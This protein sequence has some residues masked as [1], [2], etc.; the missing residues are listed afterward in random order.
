MKVRQPRQKFQLIILLLVIGFLALVIQACST[1]NPPLLSFVPTQPPPTSEP[2]QIDPLA[3]VTFQ[4]EVPVDSPPGQPILLSILDEVTGL[5]LNIS[6]QEMQKIAESTYSITLPIPVGANIKYRYARQDSFIAEEHTTGQLPVRYRIYRVDGPGVVQDIVAAW[7]DSTYTGSTGRIMGRVR[8]EEDGMPIPNLMVTA[9]GAQSVTSSTGEYLIEGLPPGLHNL[10]LYALDGGFRTYQQGALIAENSTTP[11][12][13]QLARAPLVKLIF[14][15]STPESTLP[16]VPIR[17]AGNL[18]QLGNTFADLSGGMNSIASR[19]PTL[20]SLPDGRYALEIDLPAGAFLEYKYTL[21]DGFWNSEYTPQGNFRLRKMTV[22]EHD[23][24][25]EDSIDNWGEAFNPGPLLFDLTVPASTPDFDFVSI[26]FS[27]F[28]W[29]EPIPMWKLAE[30]HWVYMLYSPITA[31]AEFTYR[32]CRNDQCGRA[33]DQLT[34]GYS[35][36]GRST[37]VNEDSQ[38]MTIN[39]MVEAWYWLDQIDLTEE[40]EF[41]EIKSRA[42]DFIA[43]VELQT[44][45][46]PSLTPRMPVTFK[47]IES[48]QANWVYLSPTWTYTRQ[49][50]P[51]LETVSGTDQSWTDLTRASELAK[52]FGF[53][54]AYHPQVNFPTDMEQWWLS[55][56]LDFAWWQVWFE[57]YRN[58]IFSFADKAQLDGASGLVLGGEWLSPALPGGVLPDGSP[59]GVPADAEQRWHELITEVRKRFDGTLFWALPADGG[60]INPPPFI[61]DLDHVY[62]LWAVPLSQNSE[63]TAAQLQSTAANY[64]DE[65]IFL[66]DISLEMPITIAAAYPSA[67]GSLQ[68]CLQLPAVEDQTGCL[69]PAL[70]EPPNADIPSL[71][72]DLHQQAAAYSAVLR[73]INARDWVD[74]FVTRGYY[75]PAQLQDKS[76]SINGKPTQLLLS[77]WYQLLVPGQSQ[78]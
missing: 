37:T 3:T 56:T 7:S 11:A 27:P 13:I 57:R 40:S 25:I 54:V 73:A 21:G 38:T 36:S 67:E 18:N 35:S 62:L 29:M 53:G 46:H 41:P 42:A 60:K 14:S 69:N 61:E 68:G 51:V 26:Q 78:E 76:N 63:Y 2:V 1:N 45:Y 34:P 49:N 70:L 12:D 33:D 55:S 16:A 50:P 52:S 48:L 23:A 9:G 10:V 75:T 43:G 28:G 20:T 58:Y 65:E 19:M 32:Y 4:V 64:L 72:Q 47:E 74:G 77:S 39:D 15:V 44:Y 5:G 59:S 24:V 22:P 71:Q 6:R 30:N 17:L 66:L 31:Q 8:N